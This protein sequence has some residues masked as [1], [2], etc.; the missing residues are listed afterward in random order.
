MIRAN[1][2]LASTAALVLLAG[3]QSGPGSVARSGPTMEG[4][5]ASADGI[6][7]ATFSGGSFTS[8]DAQTSALLAQGSYSVQDGQVNMNWISAST[9]EQRSAVCGFTSPTSVTCDQPG[10]TPFQ[11]NRA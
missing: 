7:V 5:W 10:A 6:F 4:R 11:L 8:V 9:N 2:V 3:C 1:S